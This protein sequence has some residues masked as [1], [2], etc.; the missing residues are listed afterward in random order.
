MVSR[1]PA[2]RYINEVREGTREQKARAEEL[3]RRANP[4][5]TNLRD[6]Y[7]RNHVTDLVNKAFGRP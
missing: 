2:L 1:I 4:L 5:V 6:A 7:E 3:K